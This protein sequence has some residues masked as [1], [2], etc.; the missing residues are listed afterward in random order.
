MF[1]PAFD[2][3]LIFLALSLGIGGVL[4][5]PV[6]RRTG[7][8][9]VGACALAVA[10]LLGVSLAQAGGVAAL[11]ARPAP[12]VGGPVLQP[13]LAH[14]W[15]AGQTALH[16][17]EGAL[18]G[19]APNLLLILLFLG[20][21]LVVK[22]ILVPLAWLGHGVLSLWGV[23][24][25]APLPRHDGFL[26]EAAR[27]GLP[28]LAVLLGA[29]PYAMA[30]APAWADFFAALFWAGTWI[31]LLEFGQWLH[32]AAPDAP[33]AVETAT[34]APVATARSLE[35]LYRA[36]RHLHQDPDIGAGALLWA[37]GD[38]PPLGPA[39]P[40]EPF[41]EHPPET[42]TDPSA[43]DRLSA[44]EAYCSATLPD[45]ERRLLHPLTHHYAQGGDLLVTETLNVLHV[46]WLTELIQYHQHRGEVTLLIAPET[47]LARVEAALQQ[48]VDRRQVRL[49]RR[50]AVLGRDPLPA[51][52]QVDV[53]LGSERA[54][55]R[56]WLAQG[57]VLA[58]TLRRLRLLIVLELQALRL[59]T[60]RLML[61]RLWW[62]VPRAQVQV[63]TQAEPYQDIE[64][65][66][67]DV[68]DF[69][70]NLAEYRL[71]PQLL[72]HRYWLVWDAQSPRRAALR[73]HL[74]P[75]YQGPLALSTLLLLPAWQHG[76]AVT[77]VGPVDQQDADGHEHLRDDLLAPYG[78]AALRPFAQRHATAPLS[79]ALATHVVYQTRDEANLPLALEY[80][81]QFSGAPAGLHHVLCS[82]YLLRDYFRACLAG[83]GHPRHLPARLR[84]L[85]V[86]PQGTL[87]EWMMAL[88]RALQARPAEGLSRADIEAQF[89]H[90]VP[91]GLRE[92][93]AMCADSVRLRALL[94]LTLAQPPLVQVRLGPDGTPRYSIPADP[95]LTPQPF[96]PVRNEAGTPI[97]A[98]PAEEHGVR[99][100]V[101]QRR[102]I[103][104]K[105]YTI[106]TVEAETVFVQH[107]ESE[108]KTLA[109]P[110]VFARRYRFEAGAS[111][112]EGRVHQRQLRQGLQVAIGHTHRA[113]CGFSDGYWELPEDHRP[114]A[115]GVP[116]YVALE[117]ALARPHRLQNVAHLWIRQPQLF[118]EAEPAVVALTLCAVLQ[119]CL[120]SLFPAYSAFLAV[121]SP[122]SRPVDPA[123]DEVTQF[124]HRL[125]PRLEGTRPAQE[126]PLQAASPAESAPASDAHRDAL[127]PADPERLDL[128]LFEDAD[129]DLGVVRALCD[130]RGSQVWLDEAGDYLT[131]ALTQPPESLYH[132]FGAPGLPACF[133]YPAT[134]ALLDKLRIDPTRPAVAPLTPFTG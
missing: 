32:L 130:G 40:P 31:Q 43:E 61:G 80:H 21:Y 2:Y 85:A 70:P 91:V 131:W 87:P 113:F 83:A 34:T 75:G 18:P 103:Q 45:H 52:A 1:S 4:R 127:D 63:I 11:L 102:V 71:N 17:L 9:I 26:K 8:L 109:A 120:H 24:A 29:L 23:P 77:Q 56:A 86:R 96:Y 119:D 90:Q 116:P 121:V 33:D 134:L 51:S 122:Q 93:F 14:G 106:R 104:G 89:L 111:Y 65:Q 78:H 19:L 30:A 36:Y 64:Q 76:F 10:T 81:P 16:T 133:D 67:R 47:A 114:L 15:A 125:Y 112:Q 132:A 124:Y 99:Y 46:G 66:V 94:A 22:L 60:L 74:F 7:G 126:S 20:V 105:W 3:G 50:W 100:A 49:A 128:Y 115:R 12:A 108:E 117:P 97:D 72:T 98:W 55:E 118:G 73:E 37:A 39:A 54:L 82:P 68:L 110:V 6:A 92:A 38:D 59:S 62:D 107:Q 41:P 101:G 79:E 129:H 123:D 35:S 13:L 95:P 25:T 58:T 5:W 42:P 69:P 44:L 28:L 84:P 57:P 88:G 27:W 48:Q 53:L